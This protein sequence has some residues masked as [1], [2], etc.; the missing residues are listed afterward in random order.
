MA[1]PQKQKGRAVDQAGLAGGE[2]AEPDWTRAKEILETIKTAARMTLAGQVLL[3]KEL[4]EIKQR[5]GFIHGNNQH[6]RTAQ[7]EQS[8]DRRSWEEWVKAELDLSRS[9]ADRLIK[10]FEGARARL[11][12]LGEAKLLAILDQAPGMMGE[13]DREALGKLVDRL[14]FGDSQADLL[15]ELRVVKRHVDPPGGDTSGHREPKPEKTA[16]IAAQMEFSGFYEALRR[17]DCNYERQLRPVG[18]TEV[19]LAT[20]PLRGGENK[21]GLLEL[22]DTLRH[23]IRDEFNPLLKKVQEKIRLKS[24]T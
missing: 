15:G 5:L 18:E 20:L 17:L 10:C 6:A 19:Y 11:K 21:V 23:L 9:T 24:S 14:V 22:R 7:F 4:K 16:E 3:G 12:R 13:A 8:S 1:M 2:T